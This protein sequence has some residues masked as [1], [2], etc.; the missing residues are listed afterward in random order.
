MNVNWTLLKHAVQS[1]IVAAIVAGLQ[2][3]ETVDFGSIFGDGGALVSGIV[4]LVVS[5]VL[6]RIRAAEKVSK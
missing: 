4:A 3:T 2:A 1:I 6:Q 5:Y